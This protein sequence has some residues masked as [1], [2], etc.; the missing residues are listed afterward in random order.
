M[1]RY[2]SSQSTRI[3]DD[4]VSKINVTGEQI[5]YIPAYDSHAIY[6]ARLDG[7]E[8]TKVIADT[9]LDLFV[10]GKWIIYSVQY[11]DEEGQLYDECDCQ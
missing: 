2:D 6:K 5:Y 9:A 11:T 4:V 3:V 7:S 10:E 8:R 1:I